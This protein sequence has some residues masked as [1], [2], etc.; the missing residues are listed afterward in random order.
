MK[1][2]IHGGTTNKDIISNV[3][4][5][6]EEAQK[7]VDV[8][9]DNLYTV[10]FFD[11]A[12][13]TESIGLLKEI[14]CDKTMEGLP[15][16]LCKNL[17]LVAACNPYRRHPKHLIEKLEKAGLGYHVRANET[18]D[19]LGRIP[20]RRLVYR[21]QPLPQSLLPFVWDFGQLTIE[22]EELYIRQMVKRYVENHIPQSEDCIDVIS[23][24]LTQ[25][26]KYMRTLKDE[27]SFV[28]LRDVDRVLQI[29]CW[30]Y[31][32]PDGSFFEKADKKLKLK[33][34]TQAFENTTFH[35]LKL[36]KVTRSLVLALGV[37]YH[38]CVNDRQNY[39]SFIA[40]FFRQPCALP[41]G[42]DQ[43]WEEI[44]SCQEVIIEAVTL[45]KDIARNLALKENVYMMVVCIELRIPLFLVGKP[46]SSKSLARLIVADAMQGSSSKN[47]LF[48]DMKQVQ[49]LSFQCSPH[50]T[51]A[52]ISTTFRQCAQFQKNNNLDK[53][54]SV[55]V[56]DEVG[57]AE[58]SPK[59][60]L[61]TLHPLLE[62]GCQGDEE[63][64][65]YKKVGF[66]GISNW[67]LDP[68]KMNRGIFVQ[69]GVPDSSELETTARGI[70][71]KTIA[72]PGMEKLVHELAGAYLKVFQMATETKREFFGL[73]DFYCLMKMINKFCD[74][75]KGLPSFHQLQF[76]LTRNF[77]GLETF[78]PVDIFI[79]ETNSSV[80][81]KSLPQKND[82]DCSFR[83]L[84][85]SCLSDT[86]SRHL[87]L[88]TEN[89]S[90]LS[91]F[92]QQFLERKTHLKPK[93]IFGSSFRRDQEYT[94]VCRNI[95]R[96]K[97]Y[98]ETGNTVILLNSENLYESLYEALN[99]YYVSFGGHKYVDLG[100]G[101]HR[102]KCPVHDNFKLIVVA[103]KQTVYDQFPI[104]LINRLEKHHLTSSTMLDADQME[105]AEL[106]KDWIM[107]KTKLALP[108]DRMKWNWSLKKLSIIHMQ[109]N[110]VMNSNE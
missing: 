35:T 31:S 83:G 19:R 60:P 46:G 93:T 108:Q 16:K 91:T 36:S 74:D 48:K 7:N 24:V 96:I 25:S 67:A 86:N 10:L 43:I 75:S 71:Q 5:A 102:V 28:S 17:K 38:A 65:P 84:I 4:K 59:L 63:P 51:P 21:V 2:T 76:S 14:M 80:P 68:A 69:R 77:S 41:R 18:N 94:Q 1:S 87:L 8:F 98:M 40:K 61:K 33:Y 44:N 64:E 103:E 6:N 89:Y 82:P 97:V 50:S 104:P 62:D 49:M 90:A 88:I 72:F 57:L 106:L 101:T 42:A 58:D 70:C 3:E 9:G 11:E 12:N 78:N 54:I 27:C 110:Y 99:Q 22:V 39:R 55:V 105:Q 52:G 73:R 109:N 107:E 45:E 37:C 56:L 29:M 53:F 79:N 92:Q 95:N 32:R 30:F 81:I 47:E 66:I 23:S 100:L 26:Q 34:A 85:K 20:L 15:L 13:T